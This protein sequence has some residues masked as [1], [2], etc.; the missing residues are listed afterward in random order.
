M[1]SLDNN[2]LIRLER[3]GITHAD[4]NRDAEIFA[5]RNLL[6]QQTDHVIFLPTGRI[7]SLLYPPLPFCQE[8]S[9]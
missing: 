1:V 9:L 8:G 5:R 6:S 2:A 7:I 4:G 3:M